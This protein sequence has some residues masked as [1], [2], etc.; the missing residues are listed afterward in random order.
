MWVRKSPRC[1]CDHWSGQT[2]TRASD[3]AHVEISAQTD[4]RTSAG[5]PVPGLP[6]TR[7]PESCLVGEGQSYIRLLPS[8]SNGI[9][10]VLLKMYSTCTSV[11]LKLKLSWYETQRALVFAFLGLQRT[12]LS[13]SLLRQWGG[14]P[15][16]ELHLGDMQPAGRAHGHE[17]RE[18][19]ARAAGSGGA[20]PPSSSLSCLREGHAGLGTGQACV[21]T[22]G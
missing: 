4:G 17:D 1:H 7:S 6:H 15:P 12:A 16:T 10:R 13:A 11:T 2:Q 8:H 18:P 22:V 20:S 9:W 21:V 3:G 19:W 14:P 5:R